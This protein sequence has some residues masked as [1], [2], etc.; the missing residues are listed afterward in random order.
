M[1][2]LVTRTIAALKR[3]RWLILAVFAIGSTA[4][5]AVTRFIK[6][7]YSVDATVWISSAGS[8]SGPVQAPGLISNDLGWSDLV[9]SFVILDPV[10]SQLA[11]YVTPSSDRDT[12]VFRGLQ[13]TDSLVPGLFRLKLNE[14]RTLPALPTPQQRGGPELR[15]IR[16]RYPS[17]GRWDSRQPPASCCGAPTN[18]FEVVTPRGRGN[19]SA[20]GVGSPTQPRDWPRASS[21]SANDNQSPALSRGRASR[22]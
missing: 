4:G 11:L 6:P 1:Q 17:A 19:C 9:R 18:R 20:T 21:I 5:I 2:Q 12:L 3:Y 7:K 14:N 16:R 13:P 22:R 15:G 10:V 8:R